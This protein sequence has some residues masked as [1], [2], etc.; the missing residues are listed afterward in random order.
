MIRRATLSDLDFLI[1][2]ARTQYG[3]VFDEQIARAW[4]KEALV[5]PQFLILRG[6]RGGAVAALSHLF[7]EKQP[8]VHLLFIAALPGAGMVGEGMALVREANAW[9]KQRGASCL[10]FSSGTGIDLS[11]LA[12]RLKARVEAPSYVLND[13]PVAPLQ[14]MRSGASLLDQMLFSHMERAR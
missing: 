14:P 1:H 4:L 12:K 7:Y 9:R 6:E 8:R 5:N 2:V 10:M 13:G 11:P 3:A